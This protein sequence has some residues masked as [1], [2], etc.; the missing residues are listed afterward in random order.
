MY[1]PQYS[2]S[3]SNVLEKYRAASNLGMGDWGLFV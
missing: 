1:N 3:V 2:I